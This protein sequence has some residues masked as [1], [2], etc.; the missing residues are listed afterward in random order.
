MTATTQQPTA[1]ARTTTAPERTGARTPEAAELIGGARERID[2]LDDRIIG[3][4]Q[5][6]MAVSA[7]I[8]EARI[9]SGGRRVNLSR[10]MEVLAH[11]RDALGKPG[12]AL[13]MTLLE[14]CRGRV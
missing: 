5:E 1:P 12:T 3:L 8:Q 14:L 13:A 7:V 4:V 9:G 6:R 11:Y 2:A 10:E